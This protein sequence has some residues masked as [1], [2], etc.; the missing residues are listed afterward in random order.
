MKLYI[1]L[2]LSKFFNLR[3]LSKIKTTQKNWFNLTY[4]EQW[5]FKDFLPIDTENIKKD[6][7]SL[8]STCNIWPKRFYS[9]GYRTRLVSLD[10]TISLHFLSP[11]MIFAINSYCLM[12]FYLIKKKLKG[13]EMTIF[14]K[15]ITLCNPIIIKFK[16]NVIYDS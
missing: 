3:L 10:K 11:K 1:N 14:D 12:K 4:L 8:Y 6:S 5:E 2:V 16:I 7:L 9:L 13:K 15:F